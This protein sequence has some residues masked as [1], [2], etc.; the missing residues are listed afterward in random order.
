MEQKLFKHRASLL[1][2]KYLRE[3][4]NEAEGKELTAWRMESAENQS[5]FEELTGM[6]NLS[7]DMNL[8]NGLKE[9][10]SE[11][12]YAVVPQARETVPFYRRPILRW[13]VAAC[14][15]GLLVA[16]YWVLVER[17]SGVG[18]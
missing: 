15:A 11:K 10:I 7:H 9:R 16:G 18:S 12:I 5:L 3:G 6:K 1:I 2:V 4:L 8:V 14:I 13:A 17:K